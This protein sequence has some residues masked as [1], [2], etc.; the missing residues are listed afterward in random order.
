MAGI[1]SVNKAILK[2]SIE[3]LVVDENTTIVSSMINTAITG[4]A[5]SEGEQDVFPGG[6]QYSI[7]DEEGNP[8]TGAVGVYFIKIVAPASFNYE[9]EYNPIGTLYVNS[10]DINRKIR[11]YTDCVEENPGDPDGLFYIAHFRYYNPEPKKTF[12]QSEYAAQK[13]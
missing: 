11:T 6:L 1:L 12:C 9:I 3:D 5:Y 2:V 4:Y 7:A 13:A 8:Y 10:D